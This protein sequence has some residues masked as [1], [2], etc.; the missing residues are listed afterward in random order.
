[1]KKLSTGLLT[2]LLT[3]PLIAQGIFVAPVNPPFFTSIFDIINKVLGLL[4]VIF[5]ATAIIML[6]IAGI[7]F[8]TAMGDKDKL[9]TAKM[10]V[11]WGVVGI[12]LGVVA[13]TLPYVL[14][15]ALR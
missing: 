3:F 1:M 7:T 15:N 11:V 10:Y 9:A 8:L 13:Y 4:W 12:A 2:I 5:F 6:V 14:L